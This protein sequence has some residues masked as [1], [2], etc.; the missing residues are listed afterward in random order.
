MTQQITSTLTEA[1]MKVALKKH[2]SGHKVKNN[3]LQT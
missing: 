3:K 1:T 2:V